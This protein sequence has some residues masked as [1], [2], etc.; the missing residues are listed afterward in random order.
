MDLFPD[1][2]RGAAEGFGPEDIH[3]LHIYMRA[4]WFKMKEMIEDG[5]CAPDRTDDSAAKLQGHQRPNGCMPPRIVPP[6]AFGP[7]P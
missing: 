7:A 1:P 5:S 6:A 3:Q 2:H 4:A